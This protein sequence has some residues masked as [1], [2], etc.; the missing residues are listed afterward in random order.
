MLGDNAE[1][2][3][4]P[5]K[6]AM[7]RRNAKI[8]SFTTPTYFEPAEV[9]WSDTEQEAQNSQADDPVGRRKGIQQD[10]SDIKDGDAVQA[11][12]QGF[13]QH[14]DQG[15][16]IVSSTEGRTGMENEQYGVEDVEGQGKSSSE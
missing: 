11:N 10:R 1:K 8:V 13:G 15:A 5:L 3:K 14:D 9:D 4:N 12:G 16:D 6:K 2:S 7:R